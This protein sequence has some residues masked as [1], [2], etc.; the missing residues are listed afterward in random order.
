LPDSSLVARRVGVVRRVLVASPAYLAERGVPATPADLK[1][2]E[3][4]GFTGLMAPREWRYVAGKSQRSV[5]VT[6]R[7]EVNDAG[8]AI[9]VAEAGRGITLALSYMVADQ[10]RAGALVPVLLGVTPPAV[11]VQIV[12]PESR[13][14]APKL[15]ALVDDLAPALG[16]RLHDVGDV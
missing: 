8:A 10:I 11:P 15:R 6:P 9:A 1:S 14:V 16:A 12:Y 7:L 5:A 3:V 4:I 2:H 13:L